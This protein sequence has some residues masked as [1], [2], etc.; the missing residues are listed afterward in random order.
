LFS[1][2]RPDTA[3]N[4]EE[5]QNLRA[6]IFFHDKINPYLDSIFFSSESENENYNISSF[7]FNTDKSLIFFNKCNFELEKYKCKI[8]KGQ[9][10]DNKIENI[11]KLSSA[12]NFPASNSIQPSISKIDD[13]E[14]LFFA[15]NRGGGYGK[16]DIWYSEV[17]EDG[18]VSSAH[19]LG[20]NI[21]T[22]D[23]EISPFY[24]NKHE[25]L[26]FSSEWY[27]N[28]G[29]FDIFKS[30]G[31][32]DYWGEVSNLGA[33]INSSY[34]DYYY[35]IN[36][37]YSKAYFSS[38]RDG[39]YTEKG[40][41]CCPDFFKINLPKED[42]IVVVDIPEIQDNMKQL[43]PIT[44]YFHNDEP[45]PKT[46]D[47]TTNLTYQETYLQYTEMIE[48]YEEEYSFGLKKS[49]KE[50]AIENID[51][52]FSDKVDKEF[53]KLVEFNFLLKQILEEGEKVKIT[54]KGFASPL[55]STDYN[56]NLS[57]RRIQ[58]LVNYY[59]S[60][61]AGYFN[62]Y[63][64][65]KQLVFIREAFGEDTADS[66]ISDDYS[67]VKNSVYSPAAANERKIKVIAVSFK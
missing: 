63:T 2:L 59:Q 11:S 52:F 39:V 23:N 22:I 42:E 21:N 60:V 51:D 9:I 14:V 56:I 1:A 67:D 24:D 66:T 47:T 38:N 8:W 36:D 53:G 29:Y 30:A 6:S 55:N 54:I 49:K 35:R 5:I 33:P 64:N 31:N 40:G 65:N 25:I 58:S 50:K 28:L 57:K 32:L 48:K 44:L 13:N 45:N 3:N 43:I 62:K 16:Y 26:Y 18:S 10:I 27:N 7:C 15:S 20:K 41:N 12:V 19:N 37:K 34:N 17:Y 4:T 61:D 46:R